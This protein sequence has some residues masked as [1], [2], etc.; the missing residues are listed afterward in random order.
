MEGRG[1][2]DSSFQ[3][4]SH[5]CEPQYSIA[6][7]LGYMCLKLV[8]TD[9][10]GDAPDQHNNLRHNLIAVIWLGIAIID[11]IE[12]TMNFIWANLSNQTHTTEIPYPS[13]CF[14]INRFHL[15]SE[16]RQEEVEVAFKQ[17]V[18][19]GNRIKEE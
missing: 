4:Y 10:V 7:E 6:V 18:T 14:Y 9:D 5:T 2:K 12:G 8:T 19:G 16:T 15:P 13:H 1:F 17:S 3:K 11:T